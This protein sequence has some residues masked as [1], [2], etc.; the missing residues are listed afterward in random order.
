MS[1]EITAVLFVFLIVIVVIAII[2]A[3]FA[4]IFAFLGPSDLH[5][6]EITGE[7]KTTKEER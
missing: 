6:I 3:V 5:D 2:T 7:P 1:P 4:V